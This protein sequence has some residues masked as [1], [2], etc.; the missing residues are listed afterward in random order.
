[1][2]TETNIPKETIAEDEKLYDLCMI[3]KLCRGNQEQ[4][5]QMLNVFIDQVP[6]AV[7]EIRSAYSDSDFDRVKKAA[8]RIKPVLGFYAVIKVEE[9]IRMIESAAS[10]LPESEFQ[11]KLNQVDAVITHIVAQMKNTFLYQ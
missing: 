4:V 2:I 7:E 11:Y 3:E 6:K 5:K 10:L 1:M 8:H 9:D